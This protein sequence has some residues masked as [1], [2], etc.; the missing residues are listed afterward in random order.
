MI[1]FTESEREAFRRKAAFWPEAV[2][3][4]KDATAEVMEREL[5][6]PTEGIGNWSMYYF[7][8]SCSCEL[9]FC[10]DRPKEHRCPACG[11]VYSLSLIHI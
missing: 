1:Q 2:K 3:K 4:L 10:G 11:R 7:C 5:L 9:E 6:I 8:P